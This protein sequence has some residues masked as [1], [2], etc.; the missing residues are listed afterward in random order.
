M[1]K[2]AASELDFSKKMGFAYDASLPLLGYFQ[3]VILPSLKYSQDLRFQHL[4]I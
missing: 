2:E 4:L 1:G 3:R